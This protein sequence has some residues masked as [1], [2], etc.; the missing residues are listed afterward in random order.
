MLLPDLYKKSLLTGYW[1]TEAY[2]TNFMLLIATIITLLMLY[3]RKDIAYSLI[4]IWA[5]A[6]IIL[7][8]VQEVPLEL[9]IVVTAAIGI[10]LIL[11]MI[12]FASYKLIK[13]KS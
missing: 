11:I 6:G 1:L 10:G 5:F 4:V 3:M 9:E 7:K 12:G 8:R 13:K 2:W